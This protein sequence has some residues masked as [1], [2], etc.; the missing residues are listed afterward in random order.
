M[1]LKCSS[2]V[3]CEGVVLK[4]NG[5]PT[6][7]VCSNVNPIIKG[8][9]LFCE[10]YGPPPNHSGPLN[11][12]DQ[13]FVVFNFKSTRQIIPIMQMM[14]IIRFLVLWKEINRHMY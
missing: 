9:A 14:L 3:P 12:V 11:P 8:N 4:F 7:V 6:N 1:V 13:Y 10:A 2:G 5:K